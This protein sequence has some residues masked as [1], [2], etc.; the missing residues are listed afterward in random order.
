[1][2][3]AMK[4]LIFTMAIM[5]A[6]ASPTAQGPGRGGRGPAQG[7]QPI[8]QVKLGLYLVAGA[9]ANSLVRVTNAG[10]I[11]MDTKLPGDQNYNDLIAQ[12]R[13]VTD[14]PV[15]FV[16]VTHH[17]ADHTGNTGKFIEA[18]AQ[19]LGHENLKRNLETY[20]NNP[21]PAQPTL[22]YNNSEYVVKLGGIEVQVH[23][24]GRSHT[25]GD[26]VVYYPDLKVVALSDALT[27]GTTG[28]LIDYA[29][30]G[31]ALEWKQVLTRILALD[32][33]AAIPGNGPVLTKSDVQAFKTKF[34]TVI[35]RAAALVRSGVP[36]DQLLMQLKTD[37]I[38]WA[39]RIPNVD[40]FYNELSGITTGKAY[41]FEQ[42]TDGVFYATA[43]GSMVTGSNNVAIVGE[44]D[45]LVVDTGTSPAAA[46]AFVDDLKLVTSK[47]VRYVVNTH[48]HYDHTDGNQVYAGKADI[49][50]HDYVKYAIEKLDVLHREPYQTSQLTNVPARVETL[51]KRIAEE[52]NPQQKTNLERQLSVAQQGWDELK[53]IKPTPPNVTYSK[54]KV[55]NLGGRE[56]QMLFLGRGHTNG[57]TVIYL[58][59]EKIVCTGDLME[60]QIAYMGDAQFDEWVATLET[61]KKMDWETDLPGH[62]APFKD[63]G[64]I[65]AFQGYLADL[66]K[67]GAELRQQG[68]TA[69]QTAQQV[70]LTR[71]KSAFPQIQGPG[72]DIRGVRRLYQW[73]DEK[74]K[75]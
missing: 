39:P 43:T 9:G 64:L 11:L 45:V 7:V 53:E 36:K 30:G 44:R 46:R 8:Q 18:G 4:K 26:S 6:A 40:A 62:G 69:E 51:K 23:H 42:V 16:I 50:A 66:M 68:R 12:I 22:T 75:K 47:P 15:K 10:V 60:S 55:V 13:T 28:P 54:K 5:C 37:D 17:H 24:F 19:V 70:D 72:A 2:M 56:V 31:S 73:M 38:G 21:L 67:Q 59:K 27:T 57:D 41:K 34:D 35:D 32:F 33:D 25:S 74:A 48:F 58:P 14:Q 29:G 52:T 63:K 49:I 3:A 61:L 65:T 1:M 71:Y 20:Q